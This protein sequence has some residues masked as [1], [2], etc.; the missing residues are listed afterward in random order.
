MAEAQRRFLP[1][2]LKASWVRPDK[3]HLTLKFLGDIDSKQVPEL[4][5]ALVRALEGLPAFPV[6]LGPLGVFPPNGSPRVLW[7]GLEDPEKRLGPLKNR[8]DEAL[9][10][11]GFPPEK[12]PFAPHLTLARIRS[13]K[14][15]GRLRDHLRTLKPLPPVTFQVDR[16]VLYRS[17]LTPQG[18]VYTGL[19]QVPLGV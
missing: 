9:E 10:P 12:R 6:S 4:S 11:L 19:A 5:G 7:I 1:L 18:S 14:G 15:A 2:D 8:V 13:S 16:V 17:E 3:I